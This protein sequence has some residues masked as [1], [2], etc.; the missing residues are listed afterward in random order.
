MDKAGRGEIMPIHSLIIF[1]FIIHQKDKR[2]T[3]DQNR[4]QQPQ[5]II[6]NANNNDTKSKRKTSVCEPTSIHPSINDKAKD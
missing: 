2:L 3:N 4:K 1:P 5:K 6:R